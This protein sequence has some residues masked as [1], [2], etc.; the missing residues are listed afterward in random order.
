MDSATQDA[1]GNILT[2]APIG[3]QSWPNEAMD[4]LSY[5]YWPGSYKEHVQ[6]R[7]A[8]E[9]PDTKCWRKNELPGTQNKKYKR[10]NVYL[11]KG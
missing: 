5:H 10:L 4:R 7:K 8:S 2:L 9:D 6:N 1:N 3:I 11:Q